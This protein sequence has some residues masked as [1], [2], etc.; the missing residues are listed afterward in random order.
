M[1][2]HPNARTTPQL[3][4]HLVT[5]IHEGE[6]VQEAAIAIGISRTTAYKWLRR[7]RN[8]GSS[9]L[10][11][12]SSAPH[13]IP[14][15][16]S[17]KRVRQIR[18]F[19]RRRWLMRDIARAV[20]LALSTV[21]AVL[22]RLGLNR[23][24][25]LH[26]PPPIQRYERERPG[27]L[28]HVDIKKLGKYSRVG[29]RITGR[30]DHRTR[31]LGW[32]Y[33]HV[34]V[35]D[36]TRLAYAEVLPDERKETAAGFLE[37]AVLWYRSLGIRAEEVLTDNGSCYNAKLWKQTCEQLRLKPRHTRP[38]TPRTNGKAERFIQ[39]LSRS[40]AY[41]KAYT[42]SGYRRQG[43]AAWLHRYNEKRPHHGIG[44]LTPIQ[45][46]RQASQ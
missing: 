36:N 26:S 39:T 16:T 7:F 15:R 27:E 17:C 32:E 3:R 6:P 2:I 41:G 24:P 40:W 28:L 44:G 25:S 5:R 1:R 43:L 34:C 20:R 23:L 30:R 46:L 10:L 18:Q 22:K 12:R 21:A 45:R 9:G 19:R 4:L 13:H 8:E 42:T 29:H 31:G 35:D 14:H 37:R 11:D 33:V 38:Y